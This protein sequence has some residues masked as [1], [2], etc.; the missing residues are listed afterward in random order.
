MVVVVIV[1]APVGGSKESH[2]LL[3]IGTFLHWIKPALKAMKSEIR[4]S[5]GGL[6]LNG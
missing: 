5:A 1:V 4:Q 3:W 2:H 6:Q